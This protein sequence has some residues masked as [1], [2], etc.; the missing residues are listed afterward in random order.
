[1]TPRPQNEIQN[2]KYHHLLP[3]KM[4]ALETGALV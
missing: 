2:T 4:L 1:M 3:H